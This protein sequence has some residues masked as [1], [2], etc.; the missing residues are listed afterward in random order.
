M[1]FKKDYR[2]ITPDI[3]FLASTE[4]LYTQTFTV[5]SD[6]IEPDEMG[7]IYARKGNFIDKDGKITKAQVSGNTVSFESAPIGILFNT[8]KVTHGESACAV[9][10]KGIVYGPALPLGEDVTYNTEIGKS[11]Q[12]FLPSIDIV[13]D[14]GDFVYG[15]NS[16]ISTVALNVSASKP[17]TTTKEK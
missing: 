11:L 15:G 7:E 13:G 12:T 5:K 10:Y 1:Q 8:N 4:G 9:M 6:G 14:D 3:E 17:V 16:N 2:V